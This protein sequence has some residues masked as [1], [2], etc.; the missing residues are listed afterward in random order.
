MTP[1]L[2]IMIPTYNRADYLRE[3]LESVLPQTIGMPVEV[4][5]I[6]NASTDD[7]PAVVKGF[8]G[9]YPNLRAFR[10]DS[11]LGYAGNQAKCI[12]YADGRYIAI[13]CDD[14]VYLPGAVEVVL[15]VVERKE[16]AFIGLNYCSFIHDPKRPVVAHVGPV[17]D[18]E[19]GRAYDV[20]NHHSVGHFSGFVFNA[21]LVKSALEQVLRVH[22]LSKFE[23]IRGVLGELC[24]RTTSASL[25]PSF[26]VG[27]PVVGARRPL[28]V[29]YDSLQHL[30]LDSY[31]WWLSKHREGLINDTDLACRRESIMRSLPVALYRNACYFDAKRMAVLRE[32]LD[33]LF[34]ADVVYQ[35]KVVVVLERLRHGW[36]RWALRGVCE[37]Y[38]LLKPVYWRFRG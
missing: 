34:G 27:R 20:L 38:R 7:T 12:E 2:S 15:G 4:V 24:V 18:Q 14:D 11:N 5:V 10:N 19:F 37:C 32:Q 21:R 8:V 23:R 13:L 25:L 17:L 33:K 3:C 1:L 22:E 16:Y 6:D 9:Q 29:D 28:A 26:Y 35:Q 30:C 31:E 36:V